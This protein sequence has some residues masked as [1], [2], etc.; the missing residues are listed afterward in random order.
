MPAFLLDTFK[1]PAP[2]DATYFE[3]WRDWAEGAGYYR[4]NPSSPVLLSRASSH[5][6]SHVSVRRDGLE[7]EKVRSGQHVLDRRGEGGGGGDIL[8]GVGEGQDGGGGRHVVGRLRQLLLG[9]VVRREDARQGE[10][11][12]RWRDKP[13]QLQVR[14][15][16]TC[17]S[18]HSHVFRLGKFVQQ[19]NSKKSFLEKTK[20]NLIKRL[21]GG[22]EP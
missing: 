2:S 9:R 8:R 10:H 20:T 17:S 22:S 19:S 5:L 11:Y 4:G 15:Y 14:E 6:T 13:G 7:G 12:S 18:L 3:K 1:M 16:K 21:S